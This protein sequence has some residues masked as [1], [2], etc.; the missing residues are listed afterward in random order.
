MSLHYFG[1]LYQNLQSQWYRIGHGWKCRILIYIDDLFSVTS[2]SKQCVVQKEVL[3][4]LD[5]VSLH[6]WNAT[7]LWALYSHV[8]TRQPCQTLLK[9]PLSWYD[10]FLFMLKIKVVFLTFALRFVFLFVQVERGGAP[11]EYVY[12]A[13]TD[14]YP[15]W[16]KICKTISLLAQNLDPNPYLYWHESTKK[17][18]LCGKTV[19]K[20]WLIEAH[21]TSPEKCVIDPGVSLFGGGLF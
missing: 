4:V 17:G 21:I 9:R 11:L 5:F 6:M 14:L 8:F 1:Q 12:H 3:F 20:K 18:T 13:R 19:V 2:N 10:A 7:L 16:H 15:Q